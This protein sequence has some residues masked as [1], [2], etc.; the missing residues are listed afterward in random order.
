M[1]EKLEMYFG[2]GFY[3]LISGV[4]MS[5]VI[6]S[7]I[8]IALYLI[9]KRSSRNLSIFS[10]KKI[11]IGYLLVL[12]LL[13]ILRITGVI[14]MEFH[15]WWFVESIR[16]L[17][18]SIPFMNGSIFMISLNLII[19]MPLGFLI[20]CVFKNYNWKNALLSG[21]VLSLSIEFLQLF[22]GR[23]F[24][25]DD[26]IA[27]SLGALIGYLLW[28]SINGIIKKET[29]NKSIIK[30][31][32]TIFGT[33]IILFTI[34]LI[35]NGDNL[36]KQ[37]NEAYSEIG[38]S[39]SEINDISKISYYKDGNKIEII[40]LTTYS[41]IYRFLGTDIS[42]KIGS[43]SKDDCNDNVSTIIEKRDDEFLE[44]Y[45]NEKHSFTFY[46][47]K[48]LVLEDVKYILYDLADGTIY[49]A[50]DNSDKF[51]HVLKY[52][53]KDRPFQTNQKINN[54]LNQL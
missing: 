51:T 20:P 40:D 45:F 46:N 36:E 52:E 54:I 19:F 35:A 49:F 25:V 48:D 29:R 42:N 22:G 2:Q 24:E 38:M 1:L 37:S 33:I 30:G 6:Y 34:S 16:L 13:T 7:I 53:N 3:Y 23:F 50:T 39:E 18:L 21:F 41:E 11:I 47:N 17:K 8:L 12:Y 31:I 27:N 15:I 10:F 5:L 4:V 32:C 44:I 9:S 14:G 26:I 28:Q 43:Y